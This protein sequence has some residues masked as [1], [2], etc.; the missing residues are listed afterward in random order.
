MQTNE[1][2]QFAYQALWLVLV[3]S[4]P[5]IFVAAIVGLVVAVVQAATQVQEQTFQY[6]VK[7]VAIAFTL[8]ATG[9]ML[10]G[11]LMDFADRVLS[12]F[13]ELVGR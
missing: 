7:F 3:L 1:A 9:S 11:S 12:H 5:P 13:P 10:G 4:A 6:A 2:I 8:F